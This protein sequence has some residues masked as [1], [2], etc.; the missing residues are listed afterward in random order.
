MRPKFSP[1]SF[2]KIHQVVAELFYWNT[3]TDRRA[4][5]GKLT[6]GSRNF[7]TAPKKCT[8]V[9]QH[10]FLNL[11]CVKRVFC[12]FLSHWQKNKLRI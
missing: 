6:V 5:M 7:R 9:Y 8:G 2:M 1:Q 4:D 12:L 11:L 10:T 3:E